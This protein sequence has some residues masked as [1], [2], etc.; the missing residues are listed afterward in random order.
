MNKVLYHQENDP[1][2]S[3]KQEASHPTHPT[4]R[5]ALRFWVKL[6]FIS[7]GGPT[8]Q[9][10]IMQQELVEKRRWVSTERFLNALNYCML[11]PGPEAQQ[12]A[13]Y[14]DWLLHKIPGGIAAGGLFVIPGMLVLFL[15]SYVYE[16]HGNVAWVASVFSGLKP[17]VIAIVF[18][19]VIRIAMKA[20]GNSIMIAIAARSFV[21]IYYFKVSFPLI[22]LGASVAGLCHHLALA[23]LS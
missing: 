10:A 1:H 8:G 3:S 5:Q 19:A 17:A 11:L 18:T 16:V 4:F 22:I 9:I 14:I 2:P 15:L 6:G 7:F 13:I 21:A 23:T 12:F 20:L